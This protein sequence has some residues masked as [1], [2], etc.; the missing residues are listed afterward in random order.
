[1]NRWVGVDLDGM[2]AY[3]VGWKGADHIG[4][5]ILAMLDK[6]RGEYRKI[7]DR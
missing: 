1:M 3:Y 6:D 4:P 5:P 7:L 2:L